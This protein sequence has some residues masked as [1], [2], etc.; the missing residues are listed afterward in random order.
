MIRKDDSRLFTFQK[1][2]CL[3][4]SDEAYFANAHMFN[5]DSSFFEKVK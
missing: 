2:L 1:F 3:F 5:D 4:I